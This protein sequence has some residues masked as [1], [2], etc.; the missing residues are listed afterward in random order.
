M[1]VVKDS[2]PALITPDPM[3]NESSGNPDVFRLTLLVLWAE[4]RTDNAPIGDDLL[5]LRTTHSWTR[6]PDDEIDSDEPEILQAAQLL[7][8]LEGAGALSITVAPDHEGAVGV[9]EVSIVAC[10]WQ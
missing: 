10:H 4:S 8:F 1:L 3:I 5:S 7:V 6:V 9:P 2:F